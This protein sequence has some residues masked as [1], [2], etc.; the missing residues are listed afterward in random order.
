[1]RPS[2]MVRHTAGVA[3]EGLVILAT[4]AALVVAI[5]IVAGGEPGGADPALA[6]RN[7][8]SLTVPDGT[9]A[10]TT[11]A[12]ANPGTEG[13]WVMAECFQNG[14]VVYRQYVRVDPATHQATLTLGPTPSW[15]GGAAS[16]RAE[17]GTWFKGTRWRSVAST[18]FSVSG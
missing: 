5:T 13:T 8:G 9:F 4:I 3:I 15:S 18:T 1:M 16:C 6:G 2:T 10:G 14:T 12:T 11:T 7:S 17:E